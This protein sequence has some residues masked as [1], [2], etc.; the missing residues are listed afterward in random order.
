MKTISEDIEV[1]SYSE[2]PT[3]EEQQ[4]DTIE[5]GS[6]LDFAKVF[7]SILHSHT[8]QFIC[9]PHIHFPTSTQTISAIDWGSIVQLK[10]GSAGETAEHDKFP[11]F[12]KTHK[13]WLHLLW[14][15]DP[16]EWS[17]VLLNAKLEESEENLDELPPGRRIYIR[18]ITEVYLEVAPS[19]SFRVYLSADSETLAPGTPSHPIDRT[20]S[21]EDALE[22]GASGSVT[23]DTSQPTVN[24]AGSKYGS[25][26]SNRPVVLKITPEP[27]VRWHA[28]M[29]VDAL[30]A[31][32]QLQIHENPEQVSSATVAKDFT[33]SMCRDVIIVDLKATLCEPRPLM[34]HQHTNC[35]LSAG[36]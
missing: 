11:F 23:T 27:M 22:A 33:V 28:A 20:T 1:T 34:Y 32:M 19:T 6:V 35:I 2:F 30:F 9:N 24:T 8:Y 13:H 10:F 21:E 14:D 31:A 17:L 18:D 5:P 26:P 12:A 3:N 29:W 7:Q 25:V 4:V 16:H 36:V 15:S